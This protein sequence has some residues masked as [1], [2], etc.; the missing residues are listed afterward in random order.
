M[1]ITEGS[2]IDIAALEFTQQEADKRVM[3]HIIYSVQN[4]GVDRVVIHGNDT[5]IIVI[6]LCD[7]ACILEYFPELWVKTAAEI[8]L[9]IYQMAKA[10]G[11]SKCRTLPFVNSLSGRDTTSCPFFTGKK[12]WLNCSYTTDIP[13]LERFGEEG[14]NSYQITSNLINQTRKLVIAVC[15]NRSNDFEDCDLGTVLC[16]NKV[17]KIFYSLRF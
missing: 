13:E 9:H 7:A 12:T 2:A 4:D 6:C 11:P 8:Y 14:Q 15:T 16:G 1:L 17:Y 3:L 5:D 10:L